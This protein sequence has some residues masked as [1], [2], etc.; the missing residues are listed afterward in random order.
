[1][2]DTAVRLFG[3]RPVARLALLQALWPRAVGPELARR[4]RVEAVDDVTLRV[5]VPDAGWRKQLHAIQPRLIRSLRALAGPLAPRR[6]G[7]VEGGLA[8]APVEEAAAPPPEAELSAELRREADAI[9][10]AAL[11]AAFLHSARRYLG[12]FGG[13]QRSEVNDA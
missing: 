13:G 12:R 1:M 8:E 4:T 9:A 2:A 11:R 5:R 7:F 6:L 10:D 3:R